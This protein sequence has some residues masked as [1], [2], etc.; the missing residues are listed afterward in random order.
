MTTTDG[1]RKVRRWYVLAA[2]APLVII[3]GFP[4]YW[5]LDTALTTPG[6]LYAESQTLALHFGNIGA[7]FHQ[8]S[9]IPL[10]SM[11]GNSLFIAVGTTVLSV[12]LGVLAAYALSRFRFQG[13][14]AVTFMLFATQMLPEAVFLIPIYT[15]FITLGLLNSLWGLVLVNTAFTLPVSVFITKAGIDAIPLE[16]EEAARIDNCSRL[17]ILMDVVLPLV[18]PSI[19]AAAVLAFFSAWAE[20]MFAETFLSDQ[21]KWPVSVGMANFVSQPVIS[22]PGVMGVALIFSL[23]AIVF[24]LLVQRR[25][26]SG[27]T[28]GAV[29]G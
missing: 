28:A 17:G 14:G 24:F 10:L 22:L 15:L 19:A 16:L 23:P 20:F 18:L 6:G 26:V 3:A 29:K 8:L 27:L 21:S 11:M 9:K 4:V 1:S 7:L 13:K 2:A 25:I 5:M 12:V